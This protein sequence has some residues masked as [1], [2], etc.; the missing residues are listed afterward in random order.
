MCALQP[1]QERVRGASQLQP[2]ASTLSQ[3]AFALVVNLHGDKLFSSAPL[4]DGTS[5]AQS[6]RNVISL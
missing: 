3:Q 1:E 6:K 2:A 5:I 4:G